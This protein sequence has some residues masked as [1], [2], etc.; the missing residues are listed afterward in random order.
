VLIG[1]DLALRDW[2][3][4]RLRAWQMLALICASGAL[5]YALNPSAQH[6]VIASAAAFTLAALVD[7]QLPAH[8]MA[9]M[10]T[11]IGIVATDAQLTKF[12]RV[13]AI[14]VIYRHGP[15]TIYDL[16]G[17]GLPEYRNGWVGAT[18]RAGPWEQLA[19]G[20]AVGLLLGW[21]TRSRFWP[22]LVGEAADLRQAAGAALTG[23]VILAG[24]CL[25]S[26][27]LLLAGVWLTPLIVLSAALVVAAANPVKVAALLRSAA[28]ALT[29]RR[30]GGALLIAVPLAVI[31]GFAIL[32]AAREDVIRVDQ[33]LEDPTAIHV[34]VEES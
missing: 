11:T 7:G 26:I 14:K 31:V 3:H 29:R 21:V 18:P 33:I 24:A 22:R 16:K 13:P 34:D 27:G 20:L 2:L 5:T 30:I 25:V 17:L 10:A 28:A 15:V 12:E 23:A 32:D 19:V 9:G 4:M 6:I 1:L 8:L